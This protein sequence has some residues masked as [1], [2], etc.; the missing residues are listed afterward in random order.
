MPYEYI[1]MLYLSFVPPLFFM[2]M[3]PRVKSL[4][5]AQNGIKNEDQWNNEMPASEADK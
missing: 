5:D 4:R 2:V 1:L 3:D